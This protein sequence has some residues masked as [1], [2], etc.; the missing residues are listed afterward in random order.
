MAISINDRQL[1]TQ[2]ITNTQNLNVNLPTN[3]G[4][5]A[6]LVRGI[7]EQATGKRISV[8][9]FGASLESMIQK[10]NTYHDLA[11]CNN[12]D[13]L[14]FVHLPNADVNLHQTIHYAIFCNVNNAG[15]QKNV[16][17]I[18]GL[19]DL[20]FS[21]TAYHGVVA[22]VISPG[23]FNGVGQVIYDTVAFPNILGELYVIDYE[24][25]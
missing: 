25:I 20:S 2:F 4:G 23:N 3:G 14:Y 9:P 11:K 15:V 12:G 10:I 24:L 22:S 19:A 13:I 5:C 21:P 8:N 6:N 1:I 16:I 18:N 7:I 17:G